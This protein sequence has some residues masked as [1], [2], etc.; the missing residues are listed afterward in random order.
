M[1]ADWF[2]DISLSITNPSP[3]LIIIIRSC[4]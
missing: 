3:D 1:N 2:L 4:F